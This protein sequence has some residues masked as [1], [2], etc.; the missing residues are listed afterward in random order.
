M[1][2]Q[3]PAD[4][5]VNDTYDYNGLTYVWD[6]EKWTAS[7]AA[8]FEDA[9]VNVTGDTM[10]G[11]LTVPSL[12]GGPLA[13]FRNQLINGDF[14]VWQRS[15]TGTS[16]AANNFYPSAD[17]WSVT[18]GVK[19]ERSFDVPAGLGFT[20]SAN[21]NAASTVKQGIEIDAQA[22]AQN[23]FA[24]GSQWTISLHAT[25]QPTAWNLSFQDD[26]DGTNQQTV[27]SGT[28]AAQGAAV[29]GFTRYVATAT[30][31]GIAV[32]SNKCLALNMSFPSAANFTGVQLEPGPVATV[33]EMR[34]IGTE[35]ALCQRYYF[36]NVSA[37]T[38]PGTAGVKA[39]VEY[40][41]PARM[42]TS[43]T[44]LDLTTT[45]GTIHQLG[46][47]TFNGATTLFCTYTPDTGSGVDLATANAAFDA[48]L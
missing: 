27:A 11:D 19:L 6:G 21:I 48:E 14:R 20:W 44:T 46:A 4:K 28:F 47:R 31:S 32:A 3:F 10:T 9:Y 38:F 2:I 36:G 15:W 45:V 35:L 8:A 41:L 13:G 33:F 39:A 26:N 18:D 40:P 24:N 16:S 34:P 29:N 1:T 7:G 23:V 42:R 30:I 17:R 22:P 12:N 43:P 37:Y 5:F 25:V